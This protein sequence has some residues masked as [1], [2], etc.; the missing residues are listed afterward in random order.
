MSI[1]TGLEHIRLVVVNAIRQ[2]DSND[3][4]TTPYFNGLSIKAVTFVNENG[5]PINFGSPDYEV[6][7]VAGQSNSTPVG[8]YKND[9][10]DYDDPR[11]L[12]YPF[13]G[14]YANKLIVAKEPITQGEG[15]VNSE[16]FNSFATHFCKNYLKK[17]PNKRLILVPMGVSDTG[18]SNYRWRINGDLYN[19][20]IYQTN[21]T[22][23]DFKDSKLIAILW[24]QGERDISNNISTAN[25]KISLLTLIDGFRNSISGAE[26]VPFI[27]GGISPEW[28]PNGLK[29]EFNTMYSRLHNERNYVGFAD[30]LGLKGNSGDPVHFSPDALRLLGQRYFNAVELAKEWKITVPVKP[31]IISLTGL[32]D[33]TLKLVFDNPVVGCDYLIIQYKIN[34]TNIWTESNQISAITPD[35]TITGLTLGTSYNVRLKST[36]Q[37]GSVYSNITTGSTKSIV[38]PPANYS[39]PKLWLK[40]DPG[41]LVKNDYSYG[42]VTGVNMNDGFIYSD[43][44]RS[45]G[46]FGTSS[47]LTLDRQVSTEYTRAAWVNILAIRYHVAIFSTENG[48]APGINN[49]IVD[50]SPNSA[51]VQIFKGNNEFVGGASF[52]PL[53]QWVHV[54]CTYKTDGSTHTLYFNGVKKAEFTG[55]PHTPN[56][57]NNKYFF[58]AINGSVGGYWN[59]AMDDIM[60]FDYAMTDIQVAKLYTDTRQ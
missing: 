23:S 34:G 30:S 2:T 14:D 32:S 53:S 8:V 4:T 9:L 43:G 35:Y 29:D 5:T 50:G 17:Y 12:Q 56:S 41:N 1:W 52:V 21:K 27:V 20:A 42:N 26:K 6:V 24:H 48:D 39:D 33:T 37:Q 3:L 31:K 60:L 57:T 51:V 58:G 54:V 15:K 10:I 11:V 49:L 25:Q 55:N 46:G 40:F 44:I 18:F 59:N 16:P 28:N 38:S 47:Y 22:L 45:F 19:N 36:N 7:L 13:A